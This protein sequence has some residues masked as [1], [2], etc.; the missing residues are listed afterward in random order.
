MKRKY[1]M[2]TFKIIYELRIL[3]VMFKNGIDYRVSDI[4][5]PSR[6]MSNNIGQYDSSAD[7]AVPD[8]AAIISSPWSSPSR[9]NTQHKT[10]Q[11]THF[12]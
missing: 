6:M 5:M 3:N 11:H 1:L 9:S 2:V 8:E 10:F 12:F 4:R 7:A